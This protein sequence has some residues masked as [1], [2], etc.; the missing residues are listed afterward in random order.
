VKYIVI[1][2][3]QALGTDCFEARQMNLAK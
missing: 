2:L 3:S 1:K